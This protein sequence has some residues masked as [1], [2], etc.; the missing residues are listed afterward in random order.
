VNLCNAGAA[1][2]GFGVLLWFQ[3]SAF[4][5]AVTQARA[6]GAEIIEG[7][8][9]NSRANHRECWITDPDDYVVVLAGDVG[10]VG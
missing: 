5:A 10:D 6:L 7:P 4:D 3:L 8:F 2:H 9:V 1:P